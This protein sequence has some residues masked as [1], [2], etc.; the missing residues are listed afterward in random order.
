[1]PSKQQSLPLTGIK[2]L[3]LTRLLP[4]PFATQ[5]LADLGAEVLRVESPAP[6][7]AR[8]SPP[9]IHGM[10]SFDVSLN[11]NKKSIVIN[12]KDP[13]GKLIF[14]Q[15]V[16]EFDV[17]IEQFRPGVVQKLEIDYNSIKIIK[18]DIIYCQ[19]S[20][21]GQKGPYRDKPG[22]DINY[23]GEAGFFNDQF[24]NNDKIPYILPQV[25]IADLSGSFSTV[26]AVLSAIIHRKSTGLGQYLDISM[27]DSIVSWLNGSLT[28]LGAING[29]VDS[30]ESNNYMLNGK[31]PYYRVYQTADRPISVGALEP[32]FWE[33]FCKVLE[34]P[35]Y[36]TEQLNESLIPEMENRIQSILLKKPSNYWLNALN[37]VCVAPIRSLSEIRNIKQLKERKMFQTMNITNSEEVTCINNPIFENFEENREIIKPPKLGEHTIEILESLGYRDEDIKQLQL[38]KIVQ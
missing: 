17:L 32:H 21:Y 22:H 33:E 15:L 14:Y 4:G 34:I 18:P 35:E 3:D 10:G 16:K 19:L 11:R 25:P 24:L 26:I 30:G 23:L 29:I 1:M 20:G 28:S 8:F 7:L 27:F 6:D 12:L 13:K 36:I 31:K 38:E 37:N 9:Y 5:Y 2:V